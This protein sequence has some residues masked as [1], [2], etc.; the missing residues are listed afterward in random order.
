MVREVR[1]EQGDEFEVALCS[2]PS[3]GYRW[4]EPRIEDPARIAFVERKYSGA[5]S[6]LD[7]AAGTEV[8]AFE[9]L[10]KGRSAISFSYGQ[11]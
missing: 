2:N 10:A 11:P 5:L 1:V 7:G 9:A 6:S 4:E 3:T 8:F